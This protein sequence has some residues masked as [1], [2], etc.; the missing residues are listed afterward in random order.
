M[1]MRNGQMLVWKE[2]WRVQIQCV[3][4]DV[5]VYPPQWA[6]GQ[7]QKKH[8]QQEVVISPSEMIFVWQSTGILAL[9]REQCNGQRSVAKGLCPV[10]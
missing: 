3:P 8:H 6:V 7:V 5:K 10:N 1:T 2:G 4:G 9:V